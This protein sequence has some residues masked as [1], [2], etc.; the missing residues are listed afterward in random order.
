[1]SLLPQKGVLAIAAVTDVALH[2]GP[3]PV[4]AKAVA[5]RL[6]LLTP[7]YL[8]PVLQALVRQG[9]LKGVR[10][11]GGGYRLARAPGQIAAEEILRTACNIS[12][13]NDIR[14]AES[15]IVSQ[16]LRPSLTQAEDAFS[17]ALAH[18][19]IED[20]LRTAKMLRR[21]AA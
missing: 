16:V 14:A 8:E 2:A 17:A 12:D 9:I 4:T 19:S 11:P 18:I 5:N 7:R 6:R 10:G 1:M 15:S 21:P 3:R 13:Q 20:L